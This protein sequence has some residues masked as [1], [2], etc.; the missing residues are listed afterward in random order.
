MCRA[1]AQEK[2]ELENVTEKEKD[3]IMEKE[4]IPELQQER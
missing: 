2:M 4:A 3:G 1:M